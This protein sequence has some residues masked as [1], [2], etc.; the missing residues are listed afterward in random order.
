M[1]KED[2]V[3]PILT[4]M[5]SS[6]SVTVLELDHPLITFASLNASPYSSVAQ[7]PSGIAALTKHD[8]LVIDLTIPG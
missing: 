8:L 4:I 2:C 6:K 7:Q 5:R 3:S 1:S